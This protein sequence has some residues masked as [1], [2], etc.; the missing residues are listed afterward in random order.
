MTVLCWAKLPEGIDEYELGRK[1]RLAFPNSQNQEYINAIEAKGCAD[2]IAESLCALLLLSE[3]VREFEGQAPKELVL[4]RAESGKPY[5]ENSSLYF[6][7]SHSHKLVVCALSDEG[8]LGVDVETSA[9]DDEK[10]V[11]LSERFFNQQEKRLVTDDPKIFNRIWSEKE[12]TAKFFGI[13]LGAYLA[14]EKEPVP[15]EDKLANT[16]LTAIEI[17]G[18]SVIVCREKG[19][20]EIKLINKK[21]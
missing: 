18:A 4:R 7:I 16:E 8:E 12:A 11:K 3:A 10:A 20:V 17:D 6:S 9:I 2:S 14:Q 13:P 19:D 15:S 21:L 5:L 1:V